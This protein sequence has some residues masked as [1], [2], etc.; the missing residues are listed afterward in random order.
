MRRRRTEVHRGGASCRQHEK[1]LASCL[2]PWGRRAAGV[3]EGWK[4]RPFGPRSSS[5]R[6]ASPSTRS[7]RNALRKHKHVAIRARPRQPSQAS[8]RASSG[9]PKNLYAQASPKL[10]YRTEDEISARVA[11][12]SRALATRMHSR[13]PVLRRGM[14]REPWCS[15]TRLRHSARRPGRGIYRRRC[16]R[17]A[18]GTGVGHASCRGSHGRG[19]RLAQVGVS[20][21]R[22]PSRD[23]PS[24]SRGTAHV[25]ARQQDALRRTPPTIA[26][27][28]RWEHRWG[29]HVVASGSND[30]PC[31]KPWTCGVDAIV[32]ADRGLPS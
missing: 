14:F 29:P 18:P 10:P 19:G 25:P 6:V 21:K 27:R 1:E 26:P 31:G 9:T 22:S 11:H 5:G 30:V 2:E 23:L 8:R 13:S 7:G 15:S 17:S 16:G 4:Q 32:R 24:R 12:S 3:H 20:L 28:R